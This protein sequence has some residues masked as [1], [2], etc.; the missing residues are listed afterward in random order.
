MVRNLC[1][2]DWYFYRKRLNSVNWPS[3][4]AS[5]TLKISAVGINLIFDYILNP[6]LPNVLVSLIGTVSVPSGY[7]PDFGAGF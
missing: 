2:R 7:L 5:K 4:T 1:F 3:S 6:F